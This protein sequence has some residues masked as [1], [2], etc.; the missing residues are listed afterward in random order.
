MKKGVVW[1][2]VIARAGAGVL[3]VK[4][5]APTLLGQCLKITDPTGKVARGGVAGGRGHR[6]AP[7]R[8]RLLCTGKTMSS[9]LGSRVTQGLE[10]RGAV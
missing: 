2:P 8:G 10:Y 3:L 5:P 1:H 4:I 7:G 6:P 9:C